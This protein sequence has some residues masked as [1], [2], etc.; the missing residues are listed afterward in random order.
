MDKFQDQSR[1][2]QI[3]TV[4]YLKYKKGLSQTKIANKLG[5]SSMTIS[6][7]IDQAIKDKVVTIQV[8]TPIHENVELSEA[9]A[10]KF[11]L[12]SAFVVRPSIY[13]EL[14]ISVAKAAAFYLDMN[15]G[16]GDVVG[17]SGGR[18]LKKVMGYMNLPASNLHQIELVQLHGGLNITTDRNPTTALSNFSNK[19]GLKG[20]FIQHPMYASSLQDAEFVHQRYYPGY[21]GI[22]R[23]CT[24]VISAIGILNDHCL[25]WEEQLLDEEAKQ[26]LVEAGAIAD[27]YGRWF[28]KDGEF[29]N[30]KANKLAISIT[31]EILKT[32]PKRTLV[33]QGLEK[34]K[35]VSI[36]MK[37]KLITDFITDELTAISLLE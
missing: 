24:M 23:K 26:E 9:L 5:V 11:S 35:A 25:Q 8:H 27:I 19:F 16:K 20:Y 34:V 1:R 22:W 13:D 18:T 14:D 37:M 28:N 4:A 32:I 6:R 2:S 30:C 33:T 3:I 12:S 31:P 10:K 21:E 17:I 7:M 29:I 15:I 36:L